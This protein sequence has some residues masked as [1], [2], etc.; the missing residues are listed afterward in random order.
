MNNMLNSYIIPEVLTDDFT[1]SPSP[2][3][4]S[5]KAQNVEEFVEFIKSLPLIPQPEIFG[6]HENADITCDQNE[7]YSMFE[8]ILSLQPRVAAGGGLSREESSAPRRRTSSSGALIPSTSTPSA[9]V[10]DGL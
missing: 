10:P 4:P 8:T 5:P 1:F 7:T 9:Q 6:L 3:Y 2:N